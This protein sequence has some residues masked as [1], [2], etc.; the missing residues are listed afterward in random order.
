MLQRIPANATPGSFHLVPVN[1]PARDLQRISF[2]LRDTAGVYVITY[3]QGER[4]EIALMNY[5]PPAKSFYLASALNT[6]DRAPKLVSNKEAFFSF[7]SE[8]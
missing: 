4:V 8:V 3:L 1:K 2:T 7:F 5:F 6:A